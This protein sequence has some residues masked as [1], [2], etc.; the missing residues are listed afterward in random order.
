M[1]RIVLVAAM[2]G[3][4]G[5]CTT[6]Q[7]RVSQAGEEKLAKMLEGRE[8]GKPTSCISTFDNRELQIIDKTALVYGS[9]D[10]IYVNRPENP[11]RLDSNDILVTYPTGSQLCRLDRVNTVDRS[12]HFVT[13]FVALTDFVPYRRVAGKD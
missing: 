10:T 7:P 3:L 11:E 13:G 2:V 5:A 6:V 4:L 12:G 9:G 1:R 8:A